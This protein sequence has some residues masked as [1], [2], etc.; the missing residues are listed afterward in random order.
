MAA[1]ANPTSFIEGLT[2]EGLEYF[3]SVAAGT[4]SSQAIAF[5]NAYWAEVGDQA[6]FIYSCAWE[7][8]KACDMHAKGQS[9][10]HLYEEGNDLDFN[11]GLYFYE[12]LCKQVLDDAD[13]KWRAPC[14]AASQ[15]SQ[16]RSQLHY[17]LSL[18]HTLP[19]SRSPKC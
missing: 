13:A 19:L 10:V 9:L 7:M 14:Y 1:L 6:E 8:I 15:V 17:S 2:P 4:F 5:L 12:K 16:L 3:N 11:I 18:T